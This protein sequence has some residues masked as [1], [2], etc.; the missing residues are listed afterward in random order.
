VALGRAPEE[1]EFGEFWLYNMT[2]GG[3]SFDDFPESQLAK[4]RAV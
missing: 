1:I 4:F 3:N 2:S